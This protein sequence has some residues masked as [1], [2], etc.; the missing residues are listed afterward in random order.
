[1]TP[2]RGVTTCYLAGPQNVATP[3]VGVGYG[4]RT[5]LEYLRGRKYHFET[6]RRSG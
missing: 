6:L 5:R 3:F 1:M 4:F 2:T